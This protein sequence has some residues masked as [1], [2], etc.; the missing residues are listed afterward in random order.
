MNHFE[1]SRIFVNSDT[2]RQA[3]ESQS[4]FRALLPK[5]IQYPKRVSVIGATIPYVFPSFNST[6]NNLTFTYGGSKVLL[7]NTNQNYDGPTLASYLQTQMNALVGAGTFTVSFNTNT[8]FLTFSAP[9]PF[10]FNPLSTCLD[11]LGFSSTNLSSAVSGPSNVLTSDMPV[12]TLATQNIYILSSLVSG[13]GINANETSKRYN[14]LYRIPVNVSYFGL[15]SSQSNMIEA[16]YVLSNSALEMIDF[17]L[18]DDDWNLLTLPNNL[19]WTIEL[20]IEHGTY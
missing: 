2:D 14:I 15:M 18:V 17:Q 1:S 3:G 11:K 13:Q 19:Y 20:R 7:L 9:L 4:N 10:S 16:S 5:P 8:G 6:N 12:N